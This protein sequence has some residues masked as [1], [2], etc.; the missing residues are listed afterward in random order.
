VLLFELIGRRLEWMALR[1]AQLLLPLAAL[2]AVLATF[3]QK[4][5]P[6]AFYTGWAWATM[7][8]IHWFTVRRDGAL[9]ADFQRAFV[10]ATVA[11]LATWEAAWRW[12]QDQYGWVFAFGIA[13]LGVAGLRARLREEGATTA[14]Q[15]S[16]LLV[17]WSLVWWFGG[18]HGFID[19]SV[20][21]A[22]R[23]A[24]NL[25][26]VAASVLLFELVG[27]ALAWKELRWVQLV[28]PVALV[29]A[30]GAVWIGADHPFAGVRTWVWLGSFAGAWFVLHRQERDGIAVVPAA[31]HVGLF[32]GLLLLLFWEAHWRLDRAAF[33]PAWRVAAMGGVAAGGLAVVTLGIG[34]SRWP[35][36]THAQA[37][38]TAVLYPLLVLALMWS[39]AVLGSDGDARPWAY[40]PILNPIDLAQ[41]A[42]F[43]AAAAAMRPGGPA[44]KFDAHKLFVATAF[45]WVNAAVLRTVHHW[46]DVPFELGALMR[47]VV[48]QA[49]LSLLW[50]ATALVLMFL[51]GRRKARAQWM[52]GAAL[53]ALVIAKLF[54]NDLGNSGTVARIVSFIG[55][56]VFMLVIGYISP[57][58]PRREERSD[59]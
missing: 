17:V 53:L 44:A 15:A 56:G 47:S 30:A 3:A 58:P 40:L 18:L 39:V 20:A 59:P 32:A 52:V 24:A 33:S 11:L 10:V 41:L 9:A 54:L 25:A 42:L 37:F 55:V 46:A 4:S 35:F 45:L 43:A 34:R 50:T 2:A 21:P 12:S 1:R 36:S 6:F 16:G 5:H 8:G 27:R 28:L 48:A 13:G 29:L 14:P 26:M 57:V 7:L 31:Q 22:H 51:A 19:E 49:A 23:V 38:R